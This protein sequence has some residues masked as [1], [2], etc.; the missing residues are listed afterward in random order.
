MRDP[1]TEAAQDPSCLLCLTPDRGGSWWSR[2]RPGTVWPSSTPRNF[3]EEPVMWTDFRAAMQSVDLSHDFTFYIEFESAVEHAASIFYGYNGTAWVPFGLYQ[4]VGGMTRFYSGLIKPLNAVDPYWAGAIYWGND[5][6]L[7]GRHSAELRIK[8]TNVTT[9]L[10]GTVQQ[11]GGNFIRIIPDTIAVDKSDC[12]YIYKCWLRDDTIGCIIWDYPSEA[13]R[14]RL[15]T[16]TNISTQNGFNA[17]DPAQLARVDT[18]LDLRGKVSSY[19]VVVDC[20]ILPAAE[21]DNPHQEFA[22][23]AAA[24]SNGDVLSIC[25]ISHGLTSGNFQFAQEVAG[26]R[27]IIYAPRNITG[28]HQVAGV[29]DITSGSST[30][31]S[32]YIDGEFFHSGKFAGLPAGA[33]SAGNYALFDNRGGVTGREMRYAPIYSCLLFNRAL[34]AAEIAALS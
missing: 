16:L 23:Q 19:T 26:R 11:F 17:A 32:M 8:G 2:L 15:I 25:S 10:D 5:G 29:V 7:K 30:V 22:G 28:R 13:E 33:A 34:T 9:S 20:E 14:M 12:G 18:A 27:Q 3:A 24:I 4:H 31:L 21:P 1:I 6:Y